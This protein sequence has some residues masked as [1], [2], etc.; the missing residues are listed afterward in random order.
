MSPA[1]ARKA[2]DWKILITIGAALA[3]SKAM[4]KTGGA[5]A[6]ANGLLKLGGGSEGAMIA[7]IYLTTMIVSQVKVLRTLMLTCD[8]HT[9]I[10]M[11]R[12]HLKSSARSLRSLC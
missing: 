1:T 5:E 4:E 8:V 6:L 11:G 2:I 7:V 3:V 10:R 12:M 9:D